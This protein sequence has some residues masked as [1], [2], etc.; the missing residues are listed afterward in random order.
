MTKPKIIYLNQDLIDL[1]YANDVPVIRETKG[2]GR[3]NISPSDFSFSVRN[4]DNQFSIN[5]PKSFLNS[6]IW[7]FQPIQAYDEE[8][9]LIFDGI[10]TNIIRDHR[11]KTCTI[12]CKDILFQ[13]RKTPISYT[14]SDWETAAN[15]ALNIME[16]ENVAYNDFF[17]QRSINKL[18]EN[19]CYVKVKVLKEDNVTVLD[20]IKKLGKY[21]GSDVFMKQNKI[22]FDHY[23][24]K[25][26]GSGLSFDYSKASETPRTAP[27]VE[28]MEQSFFNDFSI[29]YSG[30]GGT[31]ATDSAN[32]NLGY[33]SRNKY[34]QQQFELSQCNSVDNQIQ[35]KDLAS[36]VYIG[37]TVIKMGHYVLEPVPKVLQKINFD[38]SY[39]YKSIIELGKVFK[40]S[41]ID[42][43]WN[44]KLFEIMGIEKNLMAQNIN[45][46]AW[47]LANG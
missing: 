22:C 20:I 14:S 36:A 32:D 24:Q 3:G 16:N 26:T 23:Q 33:A 44:E 15:A 7:Q 9:I 25:T 27:I 19:E 29:E 47:E 12:Q 31:P 2:F 37:N 45:I 18:D 4:F 30:D 11:N 35:I 41:F 13:N 42:E 43:D 39:N 10:V 38:V 6:Q 46:E 21:S 1:G 40:D 17:I 5:N 8:D 34:G 28:V